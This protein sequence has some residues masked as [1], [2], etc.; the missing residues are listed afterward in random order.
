MTNW[1]R[2]CIFGN[3]DH[4]LTFL[5]VDY[6]KLDSLAK[7]EGHNALRDRLDMLLKQAEEASKRNKRGDIS[8]G[9]RKGIRGTLYMLDR[10]VSNERR[11]TAVNES[12]PP[13]LRSAGY[14]QQ[15]QPAESNGRFRKFGEG[16]EMLQPTLFG[17]IHFVNEDRDTKIA[18]EIYAGRE[19]RRNKHGEPKISPDVSYMVIGV[20]S[21]F[22]NGEPHLKSY[23]SHYTAEQ[24][25]FNE[26]DREEEERRRKY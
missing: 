6:K 18:F 19:V 15:S 20:D 25:C 21:R 12:A 2:F 5:V 3:Q 26:I 22:Q 14:E 23:F 13:T 24:W 10:T 16:A 8:V 17:K 7:T 4:F 1:A 9:L 11:V